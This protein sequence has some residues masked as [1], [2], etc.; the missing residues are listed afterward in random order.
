MW[1]SF[2]IQ[3]LISNKHSSHVKSYETSLPDKY[4][5][6]CRVYLNDFSSK[7]VAY[8]MIRPAIHIELP[9]EF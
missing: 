5:V 9:S 1:N 4:A 3:K 6:E 2:T 8:A 7:N